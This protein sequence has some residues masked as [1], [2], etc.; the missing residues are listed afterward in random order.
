MQGLM[1]SAL[2]SV[3]SGPGLSPGGGIVLFFRA[4]HFS[5]SAFLR[6]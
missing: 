3:S 5:L 4:R 2:V 1:A 6:L